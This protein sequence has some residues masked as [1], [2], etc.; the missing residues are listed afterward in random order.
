MKR[1]LLFIILAAVMAGCSSTK[2]SKTMPA[3]QKMQMG[4]ELYEAEKYRKAIPYYMEVVLDRKSIYTADAQMK[5][6]HC[7][8]NQNKFMEARFE[9]E[10]LIRLFKNYPDIGE[11]YFRIGVCYYEDSLKPHYTQEET[12][13]AILAFE[14]F[15]D[16]FPFHEKNP[17]A[18][19]MIEK[20]NFKLTVKTYYNGYAYY[21]LSDYSSALLYLDEVTEQNI[22]DEIDRLA[23]YYSGKI[24]C[25]RK[26]LGNA[27][28]VLDKMNNRYPD[29]KETTK[30]NK[31]VNK[32]R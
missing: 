26:D 15:L 12:Q 6:G 28:L 5:L 24:Y 10:E 4:D 8:F 16:K 31:L 21:K 22:T 13:K 9:Y 1:I 11:A 2:I 19:E 20:C 23:L 14:N 30:I 17:D 3:E 29:S 32:I 7:Y 27:L 18:E 25:Y